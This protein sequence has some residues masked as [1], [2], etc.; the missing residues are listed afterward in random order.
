MVIEVW[1]P[2]SILNDHLDKPVPA[3]LSHYTNQKGLLGILESHTLWA[4]NIRFL[5]DHKEYDFGVD[6]ILH[7][8]AKLN[9]AVKGDGERRPHTEAMLNAISEL[10]PNTSVYVAS[11]SDTDD[12]L[13]QWRAYSGGS[14]GFAVRM[15]GEVLKQLADR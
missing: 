4:S 12:D 5:N 1:E 8:L 9:A 15:H 2:A 7:L 10:H 11:W 3:V 13:G 6:L 14:T